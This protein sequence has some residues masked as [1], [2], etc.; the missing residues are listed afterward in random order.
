MMPTLSSTPLY[1]V[2]ISDTHIGPTRS[3][4][5]YGCNSYGNAQRLVETI[6]AL[7]MQPE[8]VIHTGDVVAYPDEA[9][10]RLAESVFSAL[11]VPIYYV[12]GNHDRSRDIHAFLTIGE[13][14]DYCIDTDVLSYSFER[15]GIRF[16][17]LDARGP[18]EIDPHGVLTDHQF[19]FLDKEMSKDEAPTVL[20]VHFPALAL[21]SRWLDEDMLL[22]NGVRLH[23][24]LVPFRERVRG[25]FSGHVHR[26]IQV[27][28]DGILY[29]SVASTGRQFY[30]WPDD[31]KMQPDIHH[32]PCFNFVTMVDG[33]TIIKEHT[34]PTL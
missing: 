14:A 9:A 18:D 17:V 16:I 15:K 29:S 3:F 20:F 28:K 10:Y 24:A 1:F 6:N 33:Q 21:D 2:H 30:S 5:L 34:F 8:F 26:G 11:R 22:V 31:R 25:V 32:P 7:P 12:V 19:D 23:Q 13:K 4:E 27:M